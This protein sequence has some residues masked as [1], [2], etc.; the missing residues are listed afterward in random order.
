[1][2]YV[3]AKQNHAH[4]AKGTGGDPFTKISVDLLILI[5]FSQNFFKSFINFIYFLA[6]L[7][8]YTISLF[9]CLMQRPQA[10]QHCPG[11]AEPK[12]H[13]HQLLPWQASHE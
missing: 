10:G 2:L 13:H 12:R 4:S 1:M 6:K 8:S 7:L 9:W 5:F 3:E 11:Q